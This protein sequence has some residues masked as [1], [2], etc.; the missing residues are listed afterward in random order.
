MKKITCLISSI[1]CVFVVDAKT[2][3]NFFFNETSPRTHRERLTYSTW[4]MLLRTSVDK[5]GNVD[6][7]RIRKN[8]NIF[9]SVIHTFSTTVI[10]ETWSNSEKI[11]FWIN[12]YNAFTIKLIIDNYPVSSIKEIKKPWNIEFFSI[13]G[14]AMSLGYVEHQILRKQFS[15]PR[16]HFAINCASKSCPKLVHKPYTS[17]NLNSLLEKQTREYINNSTLNKITKS[18]YKLSKIFSWFAKD[19]KKSKGS[20]KKFIN[21]Y[22]TIKI[23]NQINKGYIKYNWDLNSK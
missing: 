15:E 13:G 1:L 6:Y 3:T 7:K 22:S 21:T 16:I 2:T 17:K 10:D 4:E 9:N 14:L 11:A 18:D 20:I 8:K 23:N 5:K 12:V 19:F